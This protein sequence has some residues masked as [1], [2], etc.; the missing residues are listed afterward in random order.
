M[1]RGGVAL[2][3]TREVAIKP[4]GSHPTLEMLNLGVRTTREHRDVVMPKPVAPQS[5]KLAPAE[6]VGDQII[7]SAGQL[8]LAETVDMDGD[9]S[10]RQTVGCTRHLEQVGR[11][12][13]DESARS[14]TPVNCRLHWQD[15]LGRS[16]D[17]VQH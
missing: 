16:L 8:P 6:H 9:R 13:E 10:P 2:D 3:H 17:L 12:G 14:S 1:D 11:A 5:R 15:D 4:C 7:N